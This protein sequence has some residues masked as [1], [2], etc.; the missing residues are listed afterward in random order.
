MKVKSRNVEKKDKAEYLD[1]LY[2]AVGSLNSRQEIKDFLRDV[3]T[4]SERIMIGRR[5]MIARRLLDGQL[6]DQIMKEMKVG[7]DTI[8]RV[9]RWLEDENKGYEKVITSLKK[10]FSNHKNFKDYYDS[11]PLGN[12]RRRYPV[13][14]LLF[15][16]FQDLKKK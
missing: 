6:Y 11:S 15:H 7:P 14:H 10:Q 3:L 16:I 12:L 5:I 13:H 2:T 4:E 9:H 1:I 8:M